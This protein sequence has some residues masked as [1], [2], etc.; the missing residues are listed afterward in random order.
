[1]VSRLKCCVAEA[2][3]INAAIT[4]TA[5]TITKRQP[6][7]WFSASGIVS[8]TVDTVEEV[9]E[10]GSSSVEIV[11]V[12]VFF[13]MG[14]RTSHMLD[15]WGTRSAL[16]DDD[17]RGDILSPQDRGSYVVAL[18]AGKESNLLAGV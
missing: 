10:S 2:P 1:M 13:L 12:G 11:T 16:E 4:I 9:S 7:R 17:I 18:R 14:E 8:L 15:F 3:T 5:I 6:R